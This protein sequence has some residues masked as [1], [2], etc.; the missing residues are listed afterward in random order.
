MMLWRRMNSHSS[1][2]RGPCLVRIAEGM[3]TLPMSCSS[4]ARSTDRMSSAE[5]PSAS[6]QATARLAT[7]STWLP[8]P[9]WRSS[10]IRISAPD[11]ACSALGCAADLAAYIRVSAR[12]SAALG[13]AASSGTAASPDAAVMRKPSPSSLSA[14]RTSACAS[15]AGDLAEEQDAELVPA[16]PSRDPAA[17]ARRRELAAEPPQQRVA[18]GMAEGVVVALEAVQ[19]GERQREALVRVGAVL[20]LLEQRA[21]VRKAGQLVGARLLCGRVEGGPHRGLRAAPVELSS[22]AQAATPTSPSGISTNAVA[23]TVRSVAVTDS[24]FVASSW[25]GSGVEVVQDHLEL[26]HGVL[27]LLFRPR[28]AVAVVA[29]RPGR[30]Y[31]IAGFIRR[32]MGLLSSAIR[33]ASRTPPF[34]MRSSASS[35]TPCALRSFAS[36]PGRSRLERV[37]AAC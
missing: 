12:R 20:E 33:L 3:A 24:S 28:G 14:S 15:S 18:G 21:P 17:L 16:K 10:S 22:H 5:R 29:G 26:R 31:S 11:I 6:A 36:S 7:S 27:H 30:N 32:T 1:S 13:S 37:G 4:A 23:R 8:R 9:G 2:L 25:E 34:S 19:I 35:S